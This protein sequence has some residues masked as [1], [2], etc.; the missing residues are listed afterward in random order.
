VGAAIGTMLGQVEGRK[1]DALRAARR[2]KFLD[3]GSK[4]LVA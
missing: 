3:M 2:R 1:P 4:S